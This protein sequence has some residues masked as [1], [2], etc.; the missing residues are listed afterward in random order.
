MKIRFTILFF[1]LI[2]SSIQI[3][4]QNAN[5]ALRLSEPGIVGNARSLSMGNSYITLS[6]DI[7]GILANPAGLGIVERNMIT[8]SFYY[9]TLD[10]NT[11]FFNNTTNYSNNA[12]YL[13]QFGFVYSFPTLR[14]SF[15]I[16]LGYN[17]TKDLNGAMSFDGFNPGNNSM[18]QE[19]SS[20]NDDIAFEL[21]LSYP[22]FNTND[23]YLYDTTLISGMLNQSGTIIQDGYLD[24]WSMAGALELAKG[25]YVGGTFNILSGNYNRNREYFEEDTNNKYSGLLD[26]SDPVTKNFQRFMYNDII[27]WNLMGWEIELGLLFNLNRFTKFGATIK[28]P[29]YYTIEEDYFI[30]GFSEFENKAGYDLEPIISQIEYEIKTP[31]ELSGGVSFDVA[32]LIVTAQANLIDYTQMEFSDG[33]EPDIR[34]QNNREISEIFR[35]VVSYNLGIE[36]KLPHL[37]LAL[38]GGFLTQPSPYSNDPSS[39]DKKYI[40]TGLGFLGSKILALD[41]AYAYGWWETYGDNYGYDLSRTYQ[42]ISSDNLILTVTYFFK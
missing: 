9:S 37:G 19:L 15:V 32:K 3:L 30:N 16:A 38:R 26:P 27:D 23:T 17:K 22:V 28:F 34:A 6:N 21:G 5:D 12:N 29:G 36:Y 24:K 33:L 13:S 10:N 35:S 1:L 8:G 14:G 7:N 18:I 4:P 40:T 39:F 42:D 11:D 31:F 25:L 2:I 41:I 20:M